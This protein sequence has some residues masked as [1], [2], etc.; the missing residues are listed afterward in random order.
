MMGMRT[1][2]AIFDLDGT[3]FDTKNVNFNAYCRALEECGLRT[4]IDY[5]YYCAFCNGNN[6]KVFLPQLVPGITENKMQEVHRAKKDLYKKYLYLAR[7]NEHLFCMIDHMKTVYQIALVTTASR[8]NAEDIL[9]EFEVE[10][11]FDFLI[12]Q[13]DVTDTKPAPECFLKAVER[14]GVQKEDAIIFED[15]E[16]GLEA[17]KLSGVNYMKVYGYN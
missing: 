10:D 7:K 5:G 9:D 4:D 6:Y 17:A 16:T 14:A 13:E 11:K 2:L 12:T 8:A 3:L 15:S 1:K